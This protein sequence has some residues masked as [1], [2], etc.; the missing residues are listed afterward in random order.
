MKKKYI[1]FVFCAFLTCGQMFAQPKNSTGNSKSGAKASQTGDSSPGGGSSG[2]PIQSQMIAYEAVARIANQIVN[3]TVH[4]ICKETGTDP[5]VSVTNNKILLADP[6]TISSIAAYHSF[7]TIADQLIFGYQQA[8][9]GPV[10]GGHGFAAPLDVAT[11]VMGILAAIR[12]TTEYSGQTF[13][14]NKA[15]LVVELMRDFQLDIPGWTNNPKFD[16]LTS[17]VSGLNEAA[18][19]VVNK[20]LSDIY[21]ARGDVDPD[22]QKSAYF[23]QIDKNFTDLLAS[24]Q[25]DNGNGGTLLT[26]IIAGKALVDSLTQ[27]SDAGTK[28]KYHILSV[29]IAAAG[30]GSRTRHIFWVEVFYTTPAP[31][32]NGGAVISFRLMN[33]EGKFLEGR[34]LRYMYDYSKWAGEKVSKNSNLDQK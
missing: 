31:S 14:A 10:G 17:D 12:S 25:S 23:A 6:A 11:S 33:R 18:R 21:S 16:L 3:D 2:P 19:G 32:Y 9:R 24:L 34:T 5:C 22:H 1:V 7:A 29:D 13:Q 28:D 30:G 15:A 8:Q 27:R 26:S 20:K 4:A